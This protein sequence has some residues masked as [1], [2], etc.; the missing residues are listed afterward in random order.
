MRPIRCAVVGTGHL[1]KIHAGLVRAI[2]SKTGSLHLQGVVDADLGRA[3]QIAKIFGVK[4]ADN[5]TS[6]L[7][8]IDAAIVAT[9]TSTHLQ[10][11]S[12][13]LAA[14]KHCFIEKPLALNMVEC[15][16]LNALAAEN[17]LTLQ[18]GH[19]ENFNP[20]WKG[21]RNQFDRIE[22]IDASRCGTYTG[23]STDIGIVM[24]LMIHDLDLIAEVI[25]SEVERI[26]AYGVSV[27]SQRED[28]AEAHLHFRNGAVARVR[29]S[30][31]DAQMMRVFSVYSN[32]LIAHLNFADGSAT[33]SELRTTSNREFAD[34]LPYEQRLKVKESLF[35]EWLPTTELSFDAENAIEQELL[36][37]A[38]SIDSNLVPLVCGNRG[39]RAVVLAE[40]VLA[41]IEHSRWQAKSNAAHEQIFAFPTAPVS[42][43]RAAA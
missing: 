35:S 12:Q 38:D 20:V 28:F 40:Q 25:N 22:Y 21:L 36:N 14:G 9:P 27:L 17:D 3:D 31:I 37:F 4:S 15:R 39:Q 30:R 5:L 43:S 34:A 10:I 29:A 16:Q 8:E 42:H 33:V 23:R 24:D 1:G 19:V 7:P 32:N 6:L 11:G 18:V 2:Q 41:A 13:L 26:S